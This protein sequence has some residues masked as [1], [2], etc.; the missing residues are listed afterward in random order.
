MAESTVFRKLAKPV[1]IP[2]KLW[3]T[4]KFVQG[5]DGMGKA[6]GGRPRDDAKARTRDSATA[7][8]DVKKDA[9]PSRGRRARGAESAAVA[10]QARAWWARGPAKEG[11]GGS[12]GVSPDPS[13]AKGGWGWR[14]VGRSGR[15]KKAICP[16]V[17]RG[18][19]R[20]PGCFLAATPA[21]CL[22]P[23]DFR[24]RGGVRKARLG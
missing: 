1:T 10:G 15:K 17:R 21:G 23:A 6:E 7:A 12:R 19:G 14:G 18:G 13:G 24:P 20:A 8:A 11:G 9:E 16:P 5:L 22:A 2:A 3:L 4:L